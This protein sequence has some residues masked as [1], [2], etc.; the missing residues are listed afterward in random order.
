[1]PQSQTES[2]HQLHILNR[3][4]ENALSRPESV[5][6]KSGNRIISYGE[7]NDQASRIAHRLAA[8][9]VGPGTLVALYLERSAELVTSIL[10][11][12]KAGAA[13][14]PIDP[15]TPPQRVEYMLADSDSSFIITQPDLASNL[16]ARPSLLI[17]D[18]I[19]PLSEIEEPAYEYSGED[20]AYVIYTS[21]STGRPKGVEIPNRA[22]AV[23]VESVRQ[24]LEIS[25]ADVV[26][27]ITSPSFDVS[28]LEIFLALASGAV[29]VIFPP[30][31]IMRSDLLQSA[32]EENRITVMFAT[33]TLWRLIIESAWTGNKDLKAVV[34]GEQLD[35]DL[36][37]NLVSKTAALWNHYGPT[38][39]TIVATTFRVNERDV[40]VPI[41]YP[42][43]HVRTFVAGPDGSFAEPGTP[44]ELLIGGDAL[45]R[46]YRNHPE[47]TLARFVDFDVGDAIPQ[48]VYRTGDLVRVRSNGALDFLGRIDNQV[49]IRGFRVE[50]EEIEAALADYPGIVE[51]AVVAHSTSME[52]RSL[53]AYY[54]SHS[55]VP[56]S[57][58]SIRSHLLTRLPSY[59]VPAHSVRVDRLPLTV[60]GKIDRAELTRR[61]LS[62]DELTGNTC[63]P[64][65]PLIKE[66]TA[67]WRRVLRLPNV[68]VNDN[69]FEM[70]GHSILAAKL[71]TEIRG[72]LHKTLPLST[73]FEAPTI[74][75]LAAII[76]GAQE[77]PWSPLVPIRTE[78][79][80]TPFFCVHPI[81]GNVLIFKELSEQMSGRPFYALQARGLNGEENPHTSIE[82]M[83]LDYLAY[84]RQVQPSGPY[85][86]GGFSAGG[87]VAFEMAQ[88]LKRMGQQLELVVLID[89]YLHRESLPASVASV[90]TPFSTKASRGIA[91]R[92]WQMRNLYRDNPLIVLHNDFERFWATVKVK[93][94]QRLQGV[95]PFRLDAMSAFLLALRTYE[96]KPIDA[97]VILFLADEHAPTSTEM[98]ANVWKTLVPGQLSLV[99]LAVDHDRLLLAPFA[100]ELAEKIEQCFKS[101][102]LPR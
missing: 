33:P 77:V 32:L 87:L 100:S 58:K 48:R 86:L 42:L 66:L 81:G 38:E 3:F 8:A 35:S 50:L 59:M 19:A 68:G 72:R 53:I 47:L 41:G 84:V 89:S 27:A 5:C 44:G 102:A 80:G 11:V 95:A 24:E 16:G 2:I 29:L 55:G 6:L 9:G 94:F 4:E 88:Q 73:L 22:L 98:L 76:A 34:G 60:N 18:L 75:G 74:A 31:Q 61:P 82:E 1:M 79:N 17:A 43:P 30:V 70:G 10:G 26:L 49:K 62:I 23:C 14:L 97:K 63:T 45:A 99:H 71:F 64:D 69:F 15:Q 51:C 78:G 40:P 37:R 96:P 57:N 92:L 36:A 7:L 25:P 101:E 13:Y 21:G 46:G 56:L 85:L 90:R 52:D 39:S 91:R 83:A 65:D 93:L 12:L 20:L 67:I 28:A 54:R